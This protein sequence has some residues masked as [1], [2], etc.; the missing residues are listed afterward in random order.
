MAESES[1][2]TGAP[3]PAVGTLVLVFQ[4]LTDGKSLTHSD[5]SALCLPPTRMKD[6]PCQGL[7]RTGREEGWGHLSFSPRT[8]AGPISV[9]S[10]AWETLNYF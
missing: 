7:E 2:Q 8:I 1:E 3:I 10:K 5:V 6:A 9:H 4:E